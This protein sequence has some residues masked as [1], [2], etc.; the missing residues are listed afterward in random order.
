ML[1]SE[2]SRRHAGLL[3]MWIEIGITCCT[4]RVAVFG[5]CEFEFA[6]VTN[7][8]LGSQLLHR[9]ASDEFI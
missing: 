3:D 6:S 7:A 4:G 5:C 9:I 2:G 8:T 1:E